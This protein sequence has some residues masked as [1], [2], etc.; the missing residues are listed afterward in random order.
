MLRNYFKI[1]HRTLLKNRVFSLINIL[2]LAI[3][4]AACLLIIHYVRFELSYE[5]FHENADNTYRVT[6]DLYNGSEYVVT[7][8]ETYGPLGPHA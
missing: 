5:N 2:G 8:C 6:L 4:I 3:G 7:D 1:A